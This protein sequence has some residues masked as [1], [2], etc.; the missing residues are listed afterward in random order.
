MD[1]CVQAASWCTKD[2]AKRLAAISMLR[3]ARSLESVATS[4]LTNRAV[5]SWVR[6]RFKWRVSACNQW[7]ASS[8]HFIRPRLYAALCGPCA[9]LMYQ[10]HA[11]QYTSL[12][13]SQA[14]THLYFYMQ[15]DNR[16]LS[17][18]L[19]HAYSNPSSKRGVQQFLYTSIDSISALKASFLQFII[20]ESV[21]SLSCRGFLSWIFSLMAIIYRL[22]CRVTDPFHFYF[23]RI[24]C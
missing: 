14:H 8:L 21:S 11:W 19:S 18:S 12:F 24:I 6:A 7:T 22:Y 16:S 13:H 10:Y 9:F 20:R 23:E 4:R 15:Y 1:L 17:L 3:S 2:F 5:L